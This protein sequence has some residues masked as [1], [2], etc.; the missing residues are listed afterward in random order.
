MSP[1]RKIGLPGL[2]KEGEKTAEIFERIELQF[3]EFEAHSEI[4]EYSKL[5]QKFEAH[6]EIFPDEI[7]TRRELRSGKADWDDQNFA[8]PRG[9]RRMNT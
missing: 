3:S 4:F 7:L 5:S 8:F 1:F 2:T 6:P 9:A